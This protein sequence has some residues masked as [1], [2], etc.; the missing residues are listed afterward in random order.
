[1]GARSK[2][3]RR[4]DAAEYQLYCKYRYKAQARK[5]PFTLPFQ[6]FKKLL[7]EPCTYCGTP[8]TNTLTRGPR[9]IA[10]SGVDR[11]DSAKGYV[12]GNVVSACA[13]CNRAKGEV[14]LST[15]LSWLDQIVRYYTKL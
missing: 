7:A 3:P 14:R 8:P 4:P 1:M 15:F 13:V 10:Y 5:L 12:L 6:Y 9:T 2:K 11:L